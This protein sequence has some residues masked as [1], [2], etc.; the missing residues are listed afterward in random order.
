[1]PTPV[2]F[3]FAT[4][5]VVPRV[6]REEFLNAGVIVFCLQRQFLQARVHVE[7]ARLRTLWPDVD[8]D[9]VRRHLDAF[10]RICDAWPMPAR[11]RRYRRESDSTGWWPRAAP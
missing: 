7:D 9:L 6:D 5:R 10:P 11:L 1:M 4:I 8:L 3:D 2:S